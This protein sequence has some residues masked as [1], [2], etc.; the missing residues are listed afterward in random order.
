MIEWWNSLSII[1]Q[2]F[3]CIAI[4]STL[5][6][7]IQTIL[8]FLGLDDDGADDLS[9]GGD[10]EVSADVDGDGI[11]DVDGTEVSEDIS[12]L[13]DLKIFTLRGIIAFF[14]VFGWVGV[15]M[16]SM[17]ISYY[18]TIPVSVACGVLMMVAI[19]FLMR[20]VMRL[21]NDGNIENRNA[22]GKSGTV[23]LTIPASR[24]GEGKVQVMI[25]GSYVERNAVTDEA[26]PIPTGSEIVVIGVSGNSNLVVKRK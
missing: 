9:G 24:G 20:A 8:L 13:A 19:A 17:N 4:P 10:I 5:V 11:F 12:G 25:Q 18:V 21:R 26:E 6:L 7:L 2:V 16:D 14:V 23:Y 15:S 22:V 1:S 3:Y